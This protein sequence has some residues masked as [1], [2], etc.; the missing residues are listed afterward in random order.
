MENIKVS[1]KHNDWSEVFDML[2][3]LGAKHLTV[4]SEYG[5][6]FGWLFV[7][8]DVIW[9][10]LFPHERKDCREV[11]FQQLKDMVVL[12]RNSIDD[13]NACRHDNK[14]HY[15]I[16]SDNKYFFFVG[17]GWACSN[18]SVYYLKK[19]V[20]P[21]E[22]NEL[23]EFL[24]YHNDKWTLQLLDSDVEENSYRVAVP[25]GMNIYW[26]EGGEY[27][28]STK[29]MGYRDAKMVW[30]RS[31]IE[32]LNDQYA[33]I[34]KVRQEGVKVTIDGVEAFNAIANDIDVQYRFAG[35]EW[36]DYAHDLNHASSKLKAV[37]FLRDFCE[38][39]YKPKT[40]VVN[41]VEYEDEQKAVKVV[42]DYF[43]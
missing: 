33:G 11:T 43:K 29:V 41:G 6:N 21:I 14:V 37:D 30:Q 32:S 22:E 12:K 25:E 34:E 42:Q 27:W 24:V 23:K 19:Y 40:I 20:K 38:F 4:K 3:E 7:H 39:R 15:Y 5:D 35:G 9:I 31:E 8:K 18:N 16:T 1:V 10:G 28:F 26:E 36:K 17:G 13:A 2:V